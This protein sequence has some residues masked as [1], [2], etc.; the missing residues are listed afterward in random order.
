VRRIFLLLCLADPEMRTQTTPMIDKVEAYN[1]LTGWL[2]FVSQGII[3]K[4]KLKGRRSGSSP[5]A[6]GTR[7]VARNRGRGIRFIPTSV[8]NTWSPRP[9]WLSAPVH[10]HKRGEHITIPHTPRNGAGSS[11]QAWGTRRSQCRR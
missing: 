2:F 11:P 3:A 1:G 4:N 10:P 6:W 8:G 5:Q 9:F 7:G